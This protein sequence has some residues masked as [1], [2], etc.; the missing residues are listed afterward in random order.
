MGTQQQLSVKY[1][2]GEVKL[3]RIFYILRKVKNL[4]MTVPFMYN[5]QSFYLINSFRSSE[6]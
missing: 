2:F 5:F 3:P 4:L 1:L 6:V